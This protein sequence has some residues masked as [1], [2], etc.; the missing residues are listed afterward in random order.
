MITKDGINVTL[1]EQVLELIETRPEKWNQ[2]EWVNGDHLTEQQVKDYEAGKYELCGT[3][4]CVAG[5][6]M[7]FSNDY[8]PFLQKSGDT[9]YITAIVDIETDE[10]INEICNREDLDLNSYYVTHGSRVLGLDEAQGKQIF[11]HMEYDRESPKTFTDKVRLYL[12]LPA[13]HGTVVEILEWR[14]D[15]RVIVSA[16]GEDWN[17]ER[18][19]LDE[20]D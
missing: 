7:I 16:D 8:K 11:L 17:G 5:W 15:P 10:T 9:N 14:G 13:K 2:G 4:A 19:S 3:Q 1:L 18:T 20:D 12:G 6:A